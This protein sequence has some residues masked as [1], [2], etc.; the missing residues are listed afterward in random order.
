MMCGDASAIMS[1]DRGDQAFV[2]PL[3][4]VGPRIHCLREKQIPHPLSRVRDDTRCIFAQSMR[5]R[6]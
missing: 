6:T 3:F 1:R 4:D 2:P 5:R